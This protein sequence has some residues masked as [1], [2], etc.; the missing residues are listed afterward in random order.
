MSQIQTRSQRDL[1]RALTDVA[2][3]MSETGETRDVYSNLWHALPAL[4]HAN[5]LAQTLAFIEAK[6]DRQ[7]D[8]NDRKQAHRLVHEHVA[9]VLECTADSL[10]EEVRTAGLTDYMRHSRR[11]GETAVY[12][13][14]FG[15]S[16]LP[17]DSNTNTPEGSAGE[18]EPADAETTESERP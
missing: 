3:V 17:Q 16:I 13:K 2:A 14:R 12:Y 7:G 1:D 6:A 4:I 11:I 9:G 5:G 15:E 10:L 18:S 8:V